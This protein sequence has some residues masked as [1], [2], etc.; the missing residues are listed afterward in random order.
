MISLAQ[1]LPTHDRDV[2]YPGTWPATSAWYA[3]YTRSRQERVVKDQLDGKA[4]ENFLPTYEKI[5]QWKDRRKAIQWPLFPGYL[6]VRISPWERLEVL[7]THGT[8][9]I[10]SNGTQ[11]LPIPDKQIEDIRNF[12]E[13]GLKV[14]PYPY[15]RVG[16]RVRIKEGPLRD[17]E[18]IL[19]RKKNKSL[20]V[21]TVE[22]IQRSVSVELEGWKIEAT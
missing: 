18:G 13:K 20:L 15:L 10:V 16:H 17:I 6:F 4:I 22:L 9:C 8:V 21:V 14:D 12:I 2:A 3:V 1:P 7:K 19:V 5:S 11:L